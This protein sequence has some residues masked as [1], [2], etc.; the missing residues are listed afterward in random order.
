MEIFEETILHY[1]SYLVNGSIAF[2]VIIGIIFVFFLIRIMR[3]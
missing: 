2:A 1:L 3:S